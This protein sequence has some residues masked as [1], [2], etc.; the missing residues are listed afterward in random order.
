MT[1]N[2]AA[3]AYPDPAGESPKNVTHARH[4]SGALAGLP[5]VPPVP[6]SLAAQTPAAPSFAAT[7]PFAQQQQPHAVETQRIRSPAEP[8]EHVA[9]APA[10]SA[11]QELLP[12]PAV[13]VHTERQPP[14]Q[15]ETRAA[16]ISPLEASFRTA[17]EHVSP[18]VQE[19]LHPHHHHHPSQTWVA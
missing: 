13:A 8:T 17:F 4:G 6:A 1:N 14:A 10:R 2:L 9:I 5:Q 18:A 15:G 11:Q 3:S 12:A 16:S 7:Q 19:W